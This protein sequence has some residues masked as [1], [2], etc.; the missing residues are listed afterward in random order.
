[1]KKNI[2]ISVALIVL[3]VLAGCTPQSNYPAFPTSVS[4]T[5]PGSFIKGQDFD[6]SKFSVVVTYLDG[7]KQTI[8]NAGLTY[9]D[10]KS[11][12]VSTDD[13]VTYFA[14]YDYQNNK[15]EQT[16]N[17]SNVYAVDY[18]TA[19]TSKTSFTVGS[20]DSQ[21]FT[22][23]AYFGGTN[24]VLGANNY[25]VSVA[26]A[27]DAQDAEDY[28]EATSVK[29]VATVTLD[30]K[31]GGKTTTVDVTVS[32][33][34]AVE[35]SGVVEKVNSVASSS[36]SFT[37][38]AYDYNGTLPEIDGSKVL[39]NVK[40]EG[41]DAARNVAADTV[42]GIELFWADP[43]TGG[44]LDTA[45]VDTNFAAGAANKVT[46]SKIA[47]GATYNGEAVTG[48]YTVPVAKTSITLQYSGAKLVQGTPYS[49]VELSAE[50]FRA[51][52][53]LNDEYAETLAIEDDMLALPATGE[54]PTVGE[55]TVT[56]TYNGLTATTTIATAAPGEAVVKSVE[57]VLK[58]GYTGPAKQYY[59]TLPTVQ[60]G[61]VVKLIVTKDS[62]NPEEVAS[63]I[64]AEFYLAEG[65]KLSEAK[66][67]ADGDYDA[68]A[69]VDTILIG[70]TYDEQVYYSEPIALTEAVP[71][72]LDIE[73]TYKNNAGKELSSPVVGSKIEYA[74]T[75]SNAS[76]DIDKAFTGYSAID[77]NGNNAELPAE[78]TAAAATYTAYVDGYV[79]ITDDV[80]IV[81]GA[82]Y[83][84]T[85]G[86]KFAP[87]EGKEVI[88]VG[89]AID[90]S[91]VTTYFELDTDSYDAVKGVGADA[92]VTVGDVNVVAGKKVEDGKQ[93]VPVK[94]S[95][96]NS[97]GEKVNETVNIDVTGVSYTSTINNPK[98]KTSVATQKEIESGTMYY[99][100]EYN[101]A[102]L[103]L[104]E[105]SVTQVGDDANLKLAGYIKL[106]NI[107]S[108][109]NEKGEPIST[110]ST[111]GMMSTSHGN[112]KYSL[113]IS[114]TN[115]QGAVDYTEIILAGSEAPKA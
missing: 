103:S 79:A 2:F 70:A 86:I 1:M 51:L 15:V 25:T 80:S 38:P 78:V 36:S 112:V 34:A 101:F 55:P 83:I 52:L 85:D 114:Y 111:S 62:G 57:V 49:D 108:G 46:D 61:D 53:Y 6:A 32:K 14:G 7:S 74:V 77:S 12:G 93:V 16:V 65:V 88:L 84:D 27:A 40:F 9:T 58:D 5:Q 4:I 11:D 29:G 99:G 13:T 73:V 30:S 115:A 24:E 66:E 94:V 20:A 23:T 39:I 56:L 102:T 54:V 75:L 96:L 31:L 90:K 64:E 97:E 47:V 50:D 76:G 21:D 35:P 63:S 100:T 44:K 113:I 104:D 72:T 19:T 107:A 45:Y 69:D 59:T 3:A 37:I 89:T 41:E 109:L 8:N 81:G 98:I 18:I 91:F 105:T 60:T 95:Y 48:L 67:T 71:T 82:S 17:I 28:A 68:L 43:V 33:K 106:D 110:P 42:D 26:E 22:V 87:K 10:T 92:T